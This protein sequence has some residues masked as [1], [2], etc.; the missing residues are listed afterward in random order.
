MFLE[1]RKGA[2]DGT[3]LETLGLTKQRMVQGD[4][5]FFNQLLL[6]MC[7]PNMSG[8]EAD[9]QKA[10]YSK[11][12]TFLNLYAIQIGL[13]GSYGHRFK[14]IVLDELVR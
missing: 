7:D 13:G 3:L 5:L 12:K 2:L 1:S 4:A 6:P 8:V 11:I 14:N 10:F 9:P